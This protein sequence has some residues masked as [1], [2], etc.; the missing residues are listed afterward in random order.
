VLRPV[1]DRVGSN[2]PNTPTPTKIDQHVVTKLRKLGVVQSGLS[3]DAE[4]LRRVSLDLTGTLPSPKEVQAFVADRSSNKRQKKIDDLLKSPAYAAWWTT[5]L[6][7]F[8]GNNEQALNNVSPVRGAASQEWY[9][10]IHQRVKNNQPYDKIVEGIVLATSRNKG[11]SF[12]EYCKNMSD[13]YRKGSKTS[14]ADRETLPHYWARRNFRRPE[15]RAI[16][17]AYTFLGIRIQCAQCHKHPFD[18][19]TKDDFAQF[20]GFF[21]ST[22]TG[23]RDRDAYNAMMKKLGV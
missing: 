10:W 1:S 21:A 17:F 16:G 20:Q 18:R 13:L 14:F 19:W 6:C 12:E 22:T 15:E 5:K 7:D 23:I 4:F 9:D 3:T 8:T 2:Y 11:E